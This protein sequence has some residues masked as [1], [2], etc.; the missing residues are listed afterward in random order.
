M[1]PIFTINSDDEID[2]EEISEEE[3]DE[4]EEGEA[5]TGFELSFNDGVSA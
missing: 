2:D 1:D 4:A 5:E 3:V